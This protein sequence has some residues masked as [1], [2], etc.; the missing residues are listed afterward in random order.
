MERYNGWIYYGRL[1][2]VTTSVV[3]QKTTPLKDNNMYIKE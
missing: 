2:R 3:A 1:F